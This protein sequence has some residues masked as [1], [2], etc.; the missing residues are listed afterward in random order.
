MEWFMGLLGLGGKR[1]SEELSQPSKEIRDLQLDMAW[2]ARP[3]VLIAEESM[4]NRS[5][6]IKWLIERGA[7]G[8]AFS[9][10]YGPDIRA[11]LLSGNP[12]NVGD[13][14]MTNASSEEIGNVLIL[15]A[16]QGYTEVATFILDHFVTRLDCKI[17]ARAF[18][19]AALAGH[20]HTVNALYPLAIELLGDTF[21]NIWLTSLRW[22]AVQGRVKVVRYILTMALRDY[23]QFDMSAIHGIEQRVNDIIEASS[24]S[25]GY[26]D[27]EER[28]DLND[29]LTSLR[30]YRLVIE[31][32]NALRSLEITLP[33][34]RDSSRQVPL[35]EDIVHYIR[36]FERPLFS[37]FRNIF[38][39]SQLNDLF[40]VGLRSG[41]H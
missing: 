25:Q 19:R 41:R 40:C 2:G 29:V 24:I 39:T 9:R 34:Y 36:S 17:L 37:A 38:L 28:A 5:D 21:H 23:I 30:Q 32:G 35:P 11:Q 8:K 16:S 33:R 14:L 10:F 7:S 12:E 15:A 3:D 1:K 20:E 6:L 4:R 13:Y 26:V 18:F 27:E 31:G 22:A